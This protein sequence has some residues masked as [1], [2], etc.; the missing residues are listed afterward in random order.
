MASKFCPHCESIIST[1]GVPNFCYYG[2]GS[3]AEQPILPAFNTME[4]RSKI[5]EEAKREYKERQN[6]K[7]ALF[8]DLGNGRLQMRLF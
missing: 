4:E 2:C 7:E 8:T 5:I 1:N 3:L 6:K